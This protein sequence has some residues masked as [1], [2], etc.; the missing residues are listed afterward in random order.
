M[1]V[2]TTTPLAT[3]VETVGLAA[4]RAHPPLRAQELELLVKEMT[5]VKPLMPTPLRAVVVV[6][7]QLAERPTAVRVL[8]RASQ[9]LLSPTQAA[10]V[11]ADLVRAA[12]VVA[13]RLETARQALQARRIP[14]VVVVVLTTAQAVLAVPAL[15]SFAGF[16][17]A[18]GPHTLRPARSPAQVPR[19]REVLS[20]TPHIQALAR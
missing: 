9:V 1:V 18:A 3:L 17:A 16:R 6:P 2:L 20:T 5:A 10:V 11:V 13:V 19:L 14:A 12:L 7:V 15:S 4:V 8:H